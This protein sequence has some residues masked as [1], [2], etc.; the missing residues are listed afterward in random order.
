MRLARS[1]AAIAAALSGFLS[2][3]VLAREGTRYPLWPNGAPGYESRAAIPE[4]S[5]EYW[6]RHINNP[7]I[8]AFLP[9]KGPGK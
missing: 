3:P 7:S 4:E 8:T 5:A 2:M 6:T 9:E 1:L